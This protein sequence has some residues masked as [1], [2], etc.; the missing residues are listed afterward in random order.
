VSETTSRAAVLREFHEPL[1]LERYPVPDPEP[2]GMVARV[3]YGGICGTDVHL[4]EGR[5]PIPRPVVFGH[6]AVGVV[7]ALGEGLDTDAA[8]AALA[9]GDLVAWAS[10]IP[11]GRCR[12]CVVRGQRTLCPN[13][14]I[15]GI[16]QRADAWPHLS[17]GWAERIVL[18]PGSTVVRVPDG[19]SAEDAISLGCAG[20][21]AVHGM[22]HL[23]GHDLGDVVVQGAGPV[24]IAAALFARLRGAER[25][26]L[27]GGPRSRVA[28]CR[29][30]DL[31]DATVDL[32]EVPDVSDRLTA[33]RA[34]TDPDGADTVIECT[35]VPSAVAEAFELVRP[36]GAV[37]V[38]GQY[39]DRGDTPINPHVIT[40]KQLRVHGSWAFAERH[41]A[42]YVRALP[43][44]LRRVP[45]GQLVTS[46]ALEDVNDALAQVRAGAVIKAALAPAGV[47][48]AR[49]AP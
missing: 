39:T 1:T 12:A 45:L 40:R 23:A 29:D 5:L 35:G 14:R 20:P 49:P 46:F 37:L 4:Q 8:G 11:C 43:A 42:G 18:R 9:V 34:L 31:A 13:R 26:V 48:P 22:E 25:V 17:G 38:L 36:G 27:V 47:T 33:V 30:H 3:A 6:E 41:Y 16:N 32:D 7:D 19:V 44:L 15:Y 2:G 21:T 28:V 24:G 10:N